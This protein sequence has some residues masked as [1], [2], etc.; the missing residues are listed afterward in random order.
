MN[1][2]TFPLLNLKLELSRI[3]FSI[4]HIDI[5]WYAVLMM[6]AFIIALIIFKIKDG[7]FNIKF[8][9][10]LDLSIYVIPIS[11]ISARIYYIL[12]NL[13]YYINYPEQILNLKAGGLAI[14]GGIIG[15]GIT[16]YIFCKKRKINLLDL[17]D[18]IVPCLALGQAIG[19]WGN[20]INVEAYGSTTNLPWRMGII[21]AGK[22][23]EVHP[24]FLYES[25]VTFSLFIL[26][27]A[28]SNKRKYKGQIALIY[29]TIYSFAR[30]IIEGLRTDSL[31]LGNARISQILSLLIFIV[32]IILQI[33][34]FKK[35]FPDVDN[36]KKK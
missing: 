31:M 16:C 25:L 5:Y 12:F 9:D 10:I 17:F 26:L 27:T 19:R 1:T 28:I 15:G 21:E 8:S 33:K 20:F 7:M 36:Y 3:A 4:G 24:T 11:I 29:L 14:Y 22:Y 18:Y 2:V 30:M 13:D 32:A 34:N 35:T 23:I 6:S